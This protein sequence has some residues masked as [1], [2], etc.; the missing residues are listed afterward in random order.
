[1]FN[2]WPVGCTSQPILQPPPAPLHHH[3]KQPSSGHS[4][5]TQWQPNIIVRL[6]L[7]VLKPGHSAML[8]EIMA[9]Y[10]A[11]DALPKNSPVNRRK[12]SKPWEWVSR[13]QQKKHQFCLFAAPFS[14][15]KYITC[16]FSN[17]IYQV[18]VQ[19]FN[20]NIWSC[21]FTRL[22]QDP[23][24][25]RKLSCFSHNLFMPLLFGGMYT[26]ELLLSRIK[27]KKTKVSPEKSDG[28]LE[29]SLRIATSVFCSWEFSLNCYY[30]LFICYSFHE[31]K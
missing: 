7:S 5:I 13:L 30:A 4:R 21:L 29:N 16:G 1:M 28:H 2:T 8:T 31:N 22:L 12:I 10:I 3:A 25:Q 19:T 24:Y 27:H 14:I 15:N 20:S 18:A 11:F 6:A 17:G 9:N 26:C 23:S